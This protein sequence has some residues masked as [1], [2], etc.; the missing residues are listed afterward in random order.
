MAVG[1][2]GGEEGFDR[3]LDQLVTLVHD[4]LEL[5]LSAVG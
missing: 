2:G 1:G 5:R 4:V 3:E